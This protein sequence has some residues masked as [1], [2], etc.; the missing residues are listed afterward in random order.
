MRKLLIAATALIAALAAA[1]QDPATAWTTIYPQ[2]EKAIKAPEFRDK[3]YRLFDYGKPSKKEGYLYTDLINSV[4]ERCSNEGGGRVVI[5]EGTWLTGPITMKSNVNLHLSEGATLLFTDDL[6]KY[7][8]VLTRWEGMDCWNYQPMVYAYEQKNIAIS[9]KGTIDGGAMNENWWRM[10]GAKKFGWEE[11]IISQRI[12]RPKLMEWNEAGVPVDQRKMGDGYGM[13]PQLVNPVK[14]ENVLIEDITL[15]RSPFWVI[16]PLL[17]E[18]LTVRGVH[19]QNAGPNGDGCDPESCN[20]VLIENCYFDTGD[21]CIAIKSGRNR[22]GR[23]WNIPSQNII[24]RNCRMKNG[25]GG[26]VIGSEISGGYRNLFVENCVMDSPDLDRVIRIKTNSCRGGIIENVFVRNVEVGQC[27]EAVLKINLVYESK[28]ACRRDFAP[29]VRNVFLENVNCKKSKYGVKIDAFDDICNVYNIEVKNCRFDGVTTGANSINGKTADIRLE[30]LT[31]NGNPTIESLPVSL[32]MALSEMRRNPLSWQIDH[33]KRLNWSYSVGTELDAFFDVAKR[34]DADSVKAYALSY[35]DS[36]VLADGTIRRYKPED[37]KLDDVKN[38]TLLLEAYRLTGEDRYLNAARQL[39]NQLLNQPRTKD[40][41]FWHKR[42][43]PRQMWLDGLFMGT[44]FY[45]EYANE[46][47]TGK[48]QKKAYD[49]I[50]KQLL[51]V[52]KHTYDPATGLYRHAWD[53][54]KKMFWA[55]KKD[56]RSAHAWG[57][58]EGWYIWALVDVLEAMP[59]DHKKR[60]E[61]VKLLHNVA[62]GLLKYQDVPT[63]LWYQVLDSPDREG[64]YLEATASAM[65]CYNLLRATRLGLLEPYYRD[66]ALNAYK[67]ILDNFVVTNPDGTITLTKCCAVAGLGGGSSE[68]RNGSFEYYISEPVRDNDAKGVGPFILASLEMEAAK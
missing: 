33:S 3:D 45:T 16:H 36:C 44:P 66:A 2:V 52:A 9:G 27:R 23:T 26:V 68:R 34:Y 29:T 37:F 62:D 31:I 61:L 49:D 28:E 14:C 17:C 65:F 21:D 13:R 40:G 58:A 25:H 5:P 39:Y 12:G 50:A 63:G 6:S 18:N 57:R 15:L 19:I 60:P 42:I 7:P 56:G 47:L 32:K 43:Y 64:N 51:T 1:A 67:G 10:C 54:S 53:E 4:I 8:L 30:N 41:G 48:E 38:G 22:D 59:Q 35:M 55:D 20:N 46:Y 11:G 24:V